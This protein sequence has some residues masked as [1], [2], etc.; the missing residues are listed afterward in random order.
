MDK[1]ERIKKYQKAWD[2]LYEA[3]GTMEKKILKG[4]IASPIIGIIF[5][6]WSFAITFVCWF[7]EAEGNAFVKKVL[8]IIKYNDFFDN[9]WWLC[10]L[11]LGPGLAL[12]S[13]VLQGLLPRSGKIKKE[14]FVVSD[15]KEAYAK[16]NEKMTALEK[17]DEEKGSSAD[18]LMWSFVL[19]LLVVL[20]SCVLSYFWDASKTISFKVVAA[21]IFTVLLVGGLTTICGLL[22]GATLQ[23]NLTPVITS[24]KEQEAVYTLEEGCSA[25]KR[26]DLDLAYRKL[27]DAQKIL[28]K[29]IFEPLVDYLEQ[30]RTEEKVIELDCALVPEKAT[31]VMIENQL[32]RE[33][34]NQIVSALE[35]A[36]EKRIAELNYKDLLKEYERGNKL[37]KEATKGGE[38]DRALMVEAAE[39]GNID[40][41]ICI[42]NQ[43]IS[44]CESSLFTN[45]E[46][47]QQAEWTAGLL[48]DALSTASKLGLKSNAECELLLIYARTR[49]KSNNKD[50]WKDT[51][52]VLR[53][54]HDD[55]DIKEKYGKLV[56]ELTKDV[57]GVINEFDK[58][59]SQSSPKSYVCRFQ[60]GAICTKLSSTYCVI[61]CEYRDPGNCPTALMDHGLTYR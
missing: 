9:Y 14:D 26:Y 34:Y 47:K 39:L 7:Y 17:R 43:L 12:F 51:L 24:I 54:I 45:E 5:F 27:T 36:T 29:N 57:V 18:G 40:A 10:F 37:Y 19:S 20:A 4:K 44:D 22:V 16:L 49:Y 55:K 58:G 33:S 32:L 52:S 6:A 28:G 21:D 53:R 30:L 50:G 41:C 23:F 8:D 59:Q 13:L 60:N 35:V 48:E 15:T 11:I 56:D 38:V 1:N 42:G 46:K 25:L 2:D 31:V 3:E 61:N